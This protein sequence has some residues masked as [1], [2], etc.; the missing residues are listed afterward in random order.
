MVDNLKKKY[1]RA[2]E[3]KIRLNVYFYLIY[4]ALCFW[5]M[6]CNNGIGVCIRLGVDLCVFISY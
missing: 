1:H 6:Y 3:K 2:K 5:I 4:I